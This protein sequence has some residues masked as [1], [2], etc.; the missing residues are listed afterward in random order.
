VKIFE[1]IFESGYKLVL[2]L[3]G[4]RFCMADFPFQFLRRQSYLSTTT[5]DEFDEKDL[6]QISPLDLV[7][8]KCR[9]YPP[10]PA[11]VRCSFCF[12]GRL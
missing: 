12:R 11:L 4:V 7:W 10:Y 8:A 5:D 1:I 9:G 3:I 2:I 6:P